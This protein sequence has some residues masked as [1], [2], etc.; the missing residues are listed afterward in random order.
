[1]IGCDVEYYNDLSDDNLLRVA[2]KDNRILL[3]RDRELL[4]RAEAKGVSTFYVEGESE[5][6]KLANIAQR[7]DL[8]L[9]IDIFFSR[10]P[11]CGVSLSSVEKNRV[12]DRVPSGTLKYYEEFWVC[13][14]CGKIYWR[15][16]H[17]KKINE[18]LNNARRL[19][20]EKSHVL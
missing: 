18:T 6:E 7:F 4:R 11:V 8:K 13:N 12:L 19:V 16:N 5:A 2:E 20:G 17:W 14:G 15:G 10:C 9:E 1:M 3:T